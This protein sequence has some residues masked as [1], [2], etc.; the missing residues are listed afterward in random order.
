[1]G[2]AITTLMDRR[3]A[4][5]T[6]RKITLY[7]VIGLVFLI[8]AIVIFLMIIAFKNEPTIEYYNIPFPTDKLE[9]HPTD[10]IKYRVEFRKLTNIP[11]DVSRQL[12]CVNGNERYNRS[13]Q[14]GISGIDETPDSVD[15]ESSIVITSATPGDVPLNVPCHIEITS[16][17]TFNAF[18]VEYARGRTDTFKFV[19]PGTPLRDNPRINQPSQLPEQPVTRIPATVGSPESSTPNTSNPNNPGNTVQNNESSVNVEPNI[20]TTL[21]DVD[22]NLPDFELGGIIN[23]EILEPVEKPKAEIPSPITSP[24]G[25]LIIELFK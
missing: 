6:L 14:G 24:V 10:S 1:M 12:I 18:Q 17:Y 8:V 5:R 13:L 20:D 25:N 7:S 21:P 11:A 9:Y 16:K 19:E 22:L 3:K 4:D 15:Y 23:S 2:K